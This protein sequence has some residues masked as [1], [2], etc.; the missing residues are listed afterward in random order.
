MFR[1]PVIPGTRGV[2]PISETVRYAAAVA[3]VYFHFDNTL[4]GGAR[5]A[6]LAAQRR[7]EGP[8]IAMPD[9]STKSGQSWIGGSVL[10][11]QGDE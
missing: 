6:T 10:Y 4:S 8:A 7:S 2:P 5:A 9:T 1:G 11:V 3:N